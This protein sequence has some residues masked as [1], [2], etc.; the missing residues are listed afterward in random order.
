MSPAAPGEVAERGNTP[1]API[2]GNCFGDLFGPAP[3]LAAV[4][5][6]VEAGNITGCSGGEPKT[7]GF[8]ANSRRL[9]LGLVPL[10]RRA[11]LGG[12]RPGAGAWPGAG[13]AAV[14]VDA[15]DAVVAGAGRGGT[16]AM[17]G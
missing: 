5:G 7:G 9:G 15:V 11:V 6:E 4:V 10:I 3:A 1:P 17:M 2:G 8:T 14:V 12:D 16:A 13:A